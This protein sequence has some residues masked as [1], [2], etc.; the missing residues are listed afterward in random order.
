LGGLYAVAE[1]ISYD[2]QH[3]KGI[4]ILDMTESICSNTLQI[5]SGT[6]GSGPQLSQMCHT[7]DREVVTSSGNSMFVRFESD[8]LYSGKGFRASYR[9]VDSSKSII[10]APHNYNLLPVLSCELFSVPT[11]LSYMI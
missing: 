6:D 4:P 9:T 2:T 8:M 1:I 11:L 10:T 7:H 3:V 5:Y